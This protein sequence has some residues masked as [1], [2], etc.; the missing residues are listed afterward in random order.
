MSTMPW[1]RADFNDNFPNPTIGTYDTGAIA[2]STVRLDM[3]LHF[4]GDLKLRLEME[5]L[6]EHILS[7]LSKEW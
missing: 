1:V 6:N 2:P 7:L 4:G 3:P 5:L